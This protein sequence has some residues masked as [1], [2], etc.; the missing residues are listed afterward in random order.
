MLRRGQPAGLPDLERAGCLIDA[1]AQPIFLKRVKPPK[2]VILTEW[3]FVLYYYV[4]CLKETR[5]TTT[6]ATADRRKNDPA[7]P[8]KKTRVTRGKALPKVS[9]GQKA[10]TKLFLQ[11]DM[12]LLANKIGAMAFEDRGWAQL[13]NYVANLAPIERHDAA[14]DGVSTKVLQLVVE[15]FKTISKPEIYE[16][17][18]LSSKTV[19]RRKDQALPRAASD[20]TIDLIGISSLAETVFGSQSD[21]EAWLRTPALALDGKKPIDLI[22]TR[23]GAELVR[24]Q[25]VRLDY[26]VYS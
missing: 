12:K 13:S 18:G 1:C 4:K 9:D 23:A 14:R 8:P 22:A 10:D 7:A 17:V 15:S 11:N 16:I 2:I 20:A 5:M 3:T 24:D 6:A 25:L 21:A 19:S 26:G